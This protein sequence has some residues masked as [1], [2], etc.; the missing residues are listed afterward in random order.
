MSQSRS[1]RDT[2][3]LTNLKMC[4][5]GSHYFL[6]QPRTA[7]YPG[8]SIERVIQQLDCLPH[9]IA[10]RWYHTTPVHMCSGS[11]TNRHNLRFAGL[12][13][14]LLNPSTEALCSF[15]SRMS[16]LADFVLDCWLDPSSCCSCCIPAP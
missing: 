8:C 6:R 12:R 1:L 11:R 10:A 13:L 15:G 3:W 2:A 4:R 9:W 14:Q 16:I 7:R 5:P